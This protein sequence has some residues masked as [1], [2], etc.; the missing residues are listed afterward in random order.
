[1]AKK[2]KK[3]DIEVIVWQDHCTEQGWQDSG[4]KFT[5]PIVTTVGFLVSDSKNLVS[6]AQTKDLIT[7]YKYSDV[8]NVGTIIKKNILYWQTF[9]IEIEEP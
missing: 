5:V 8:C 4:D 7:K 2:T 1:M 3:I 9:E 6:I